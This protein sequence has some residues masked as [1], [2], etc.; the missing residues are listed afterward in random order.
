MIRPRRA[1]LLAALLASC[2]PL[3]AAQQPREQDRVMKATPGTPFVLDFSGAP[4]GG[5]SAGSFNNLAFSLNLR[6]PVRKVVIRRQERLPDVLPTHDYADCT[7][8]QEPLLESQIRELPRGEP[9]FVDRIDVELLPF[10]QKGLTI[11]ASLCYGVRAAQGAW[12]WRLEKVPLTL[13]A[14][15]NRL[16]GQWWVKEANVDAIKLVFDGAM[17]RH[18]LRSVTVT[19]QLP[20]ND[21]PR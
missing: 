20:S 18:Y 16:R 1:L 9:S 14:A 8:G 21:R 11:D 5:V 7:P 13:D 10:P 6:Q 3:M 4:D 2:P 19:T 12:H 17:P 15:T